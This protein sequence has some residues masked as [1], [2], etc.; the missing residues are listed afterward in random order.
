MLAPAPNPALTTV[1]LAPLMEPPSQSPTGSSMAGG[2]SNLDDFKKQA[3]EY[4]EAR[5]KAYLEKQ[6]NVVQPTEAHASP[7]STQSGFD[8][9]S[10]NDVPAAPPNP[11]SSTAYPGLLMEPPSRSPTGSSMAWGYSNF[12][13]FA[14]HFEAQRKA[15]LEKQRNAVQP[16][17]AHASPSSALSGFDHGSKND[18]PA[19]P[20]NPASSTAYTGLLMEPPSQSPTGSSM[21]WGYS[22]FDDFAKQSFEARR[23][24][25]FEKQSKAVKSTEAHASPSSALPGFDHGSKND[26]PAAPPNPASSTAYPGLLMEPPS[27]SP[28]GS[29]MAWG[30]SNFD[31]FVK[32]RK[33]SFEARRKAYLEKQS[34]AVKSTEAHA[35]PSLALSGSDHGSKND[36]PAAPPNPASSTTY[37]GLLMNPASSLPPTAPG[38]DATL[39]DKWWYNGPDGPMYTPMS[40]GYGSDHVST[41]VHAPQPKPNPRPSKNPYFAWNHLMENPPPVR[42]APPIEFVQTH[43]N[44]AVHVQDTNPGPPTDPEFDWDYWMDN[45][46][47]PKRLRPGSSNELDDEAFQG[48]LSPECADSQPGDLWVTSYA[49][50]GKAKKLRRIFGTATGS[51]VGN[52]VIRQRKFQP[53]DRLLGPWGFSDEEFWKFLNNFHGPGTAI[54]PHIIEIIWHDL[55]CSWEV[56]Y[57]S[58]ECGGRGATH[59]AY[60]PGIARVAERVRLNSPRNSLRIDGFITPNSHKWMRHG[61][62]KP[63]SRE[64][65]AWRI[66]REIPAVSNF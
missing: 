52:V 49:A 64:P 45:L 39:Q 9:G 37:P 23:K 2:N 16:T 13:D 12:D 31:D 11:A 32:Q 35:S 50:K 66:C 61:P 15:Y 6:R 36:V 47:S 21:A 56:L 59:C 44:Q 19:A 41:G 54:H 17:E 51:D 20:P 3:K 28:T 53:A 14:K 27:Q 30:Y 42:P 65:N 33:E 48:P 29:S 60:W 25:F 7:S 62:N 63:A 5:R 24:A 38:I 4:F 57:R 43:E 40:L 8:H 46:P 26:V 55:L 18:V 10:K 34:K 1:N 58:R 22:N